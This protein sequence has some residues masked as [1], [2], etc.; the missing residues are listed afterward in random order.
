MT[1]PNDAL[2]TLFHAC[3]DSV[4]A[5]QKW[6]VTLLILKQGRAVDDPESYWLV[7]LECCPLNVL[8]LLLDGRLR[9]WA[10]ANNDN[11]L[12]LLCA[13]QRARAEGKTL[14]VF[15]GDM[16]NAFP[17]TDVG[18]LWADM[19]AAGVSGPFFDLMRMLYARMSYA[20]KFGDDHSMPFR[21]LIDFRLSPHKDVIRLNGHP[22][23][24]VE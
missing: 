3:L 4:H 7:G 20:V 6:L 1:I 21:S 17:Y 5:P 13:I 9:E 23:S 15:F 10:A 2:V 11:S 19:Y 24:Q 16:T 22:V 18:R 12:V 8:T 14:C